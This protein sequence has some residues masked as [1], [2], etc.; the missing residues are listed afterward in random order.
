MEKKIAHYSL[1]AIKDLIQDEQYFITRTARVDY[2]A[3]GFEDDEV[4][5]IILSLTNKNLYKSM[6]TYQNNKIW[7]DVYFKKINNIELYIKLQ[8]SEQAIIISFKERT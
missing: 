7:Q 4:I 2:V 3:L 1:F 6:T 8:I 5:D